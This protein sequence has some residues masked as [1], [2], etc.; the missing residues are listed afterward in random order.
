MAGVKEKAPGYPRRGEVR[1]LHLSPPCQSLSQSNRHSDMRK[2]NDVLLP[3]LAQVNPPPPPPLPFHNHLSIRLRFGGREF[4]D[5][6]RPSDERNSARMNASGSSCPAAM[7]GGFRVCSG[8]YCLST[9]PADLQFVRHTVLPRSH[10]PK[11]ATH[12]E[13]GCQQMWQTSELRG[14]VCSARG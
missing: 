9:T 10:E 13:T 12:S 7:F 3:L 2:V 5:D 11:I 4:V 1:V 8:V 6:W 14:L